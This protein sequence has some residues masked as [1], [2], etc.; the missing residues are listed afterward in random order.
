MDTKPSFS[1]TK[2]ATFVI[3]GGLGGIGR[4]IAAWLVERGARNLILLSR[5]GASNPHAQALV[6]ELTSKGACVQ[7]PGCDISDK[8]ALE[9]T[10]A[11]CL[12]NANMPPIK[13]CIQASMVLRDAAFAGMTHEAWT[14]AT[15]P[16]VQGS[17]NLHTV[18]PS[19]LDFFVTLSSI[20]G[21]VG[22]RGQANYAAGNAFQDALVHH[23]I[24]H[25]QR[26]AAIDLGP[27]FSIGV[28]TE[29][30]EL[31]A[32]W[33]EM[34]DA[35]VTEAD[36][37]ALLD[38]YCNPAEDSQGRDGANSAPLRCQAVVG[39]ARWL[40]DKTAL[41]FKKPMMRN[42]TMDQ[43]G[44]GAAGADRGDSH[45]VNFAAVFAGAESLG[46]VVEAVTDA[47]T[48]KMASTL[49]LS[50][51]EID[52]ATPMHSYG[53]D[54]LVAVELRNWFAKELHA[55]VAIFD[56]LGGATISTASVLAA[57]KSKYRKAEWAE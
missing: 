30:A 20:T 40:S 32:R 36:L 21:V 1:L 44:T 43:D 37:F 51:E 28:M 52:L 22:S 54:S 33:E 26:A 55:D 5:S 18:L 29:N 7:T 48:R 47:L 3:A 45:R 50:R 11:A 39:L 17:W 8:N 19:D 25:G 6:D 46:E 35:P 16:K 42:L 38:Y 24:A 41:Y 12:K 49:S 23:R 4:S 10:L 15:A 56:I 9:S 57:T 2:D 14:A 34:V 53:V 13:G 27:F 31:K